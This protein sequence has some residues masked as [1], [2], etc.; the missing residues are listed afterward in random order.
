MADPVIKPKLQ[1]ASRVWSAHSR[2]HTDLLEEVHRRARKTAPRQKGAEPQREA[3]GRGV[4]QGERKRER[5][6]RVEGMITYDSLTTPDGVTTAQF[7]K[8]WKCQVGKRA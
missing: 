5:D 2:E 8:T 4:T 3:G 1:C 7:L 6:A